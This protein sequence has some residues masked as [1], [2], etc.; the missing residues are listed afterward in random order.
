MSAILASLVVCGGAAL[1]HMNELGPHNENNNATM[2][3]HKN[4]NFGGA[5]TAALNNFSE[6]ETGGLNDAPYPRVVTVFANADQEVIRQPCV[7]DGDS[8]SFFMHRV[9]GPDLVSM[10]DC[11]E[12]PKFILTHELKHSYGGQHIENCN[13]AIE[14]DPRYL[15]AIRRSVMCRARWDSGDLTRHDKYDLRN[16]PNER[17]NGSTLAAS[18]AEEGHAIPSEAKP[19][20]QYRESIIP[21]WAHKVKPSAGDYIIEEHFKTR[22]PAAKAD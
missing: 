17:L 9:N 16:I 12:Y 21:S 4:Q 10:G 19:V 11:V 20:P 7:D 14:P 2:D 6:E 18:S 5:F 13:E 3:L 1:A 22:I 8:E 15:P